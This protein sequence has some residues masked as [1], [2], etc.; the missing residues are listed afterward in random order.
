MLDKNSKL[1]IPNYKQIQNIKIKTPK[2]I[3]NRC[4]LYLYYFTNFLTL[5]FLTKEY[6]HF[7]FLSFLLPNKLLHHKQQ[8]TVREIP[9]SAVYQK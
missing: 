9:P 4:A 2:L 8:E 1:Q 7:T 5:Y 6:L 3:K